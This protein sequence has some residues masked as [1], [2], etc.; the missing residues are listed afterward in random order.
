VFLGN[1]IKDK[2]ETAG[3]KSRRFGWTKVVVSKIWNSCPE[4]L[5]SLCGSG[6]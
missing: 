4:K 6:S 5:K 3:I 2:N 1:G